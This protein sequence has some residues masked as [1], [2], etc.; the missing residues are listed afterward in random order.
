MEVWGL[1]E[2]RDNLARVRKWREEKARV[3]EE[4]GPQEEEPEY[5]RTLPRSPPYI[6][7]ASFSYDVHSPHHIQTFPVLPEIRGLGVDIGVVVLMVK[8]NWGRA[9]FT[10]LYRLRVHGEQ[11]GE[12]PPPLAADSP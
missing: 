11:M 8:S 9:D 6:R 10:C 12:N 5:P 1:V 2:G 3:R 4:G 7:L